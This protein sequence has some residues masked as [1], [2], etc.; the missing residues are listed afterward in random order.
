MH[1]LLWG[2]GVAGIVGVSVVGYLLL[3]T[4]SSMNNSASGE[5]IV[6]VS[7]NEEVS[8]QP[9]SGK[10]S[11]MALLSRAED[12]E[13]AI[14]YENNPSSTTVSG[15]YFT[16]EGKLRGDFVI[17]ELGEGGVSSMILRDNT[18]Y[19]WTIMNGEGYGMQI[20]LETLAANKKEESAPD[21]NEP[22][23]LDTPVEYSCKAWTAKDDSI[24][25]LPSE[26]LFKEYSSL[27]G[28]GMEY[29]TTY[30]VA[31]SGPASSPCELCNQVPA[32]VGQDECKARFQCQ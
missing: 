22:V 11:L 9:I 19:T 13:C 8:K 14:T 6:E 30:E 5:D 3:R 23:P 28:A 12:L 2:L 15:T 7:D 24:F 1:K 4:D 17:P 16:S 21:T 25:E 18:L 32:G 27:M 29:G 10:E 20:D 31:P 26:V